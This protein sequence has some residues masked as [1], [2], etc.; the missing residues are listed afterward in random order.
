LDLLLYLLR[1]RRIDGGFGI[2]NL[3]HHSDFYPPVL[4]GDMYRPGS[5]L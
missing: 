1:L 4:R 2:V 5:S 3:A